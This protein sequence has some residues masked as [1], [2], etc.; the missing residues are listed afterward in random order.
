[1]IFPIVLRAWVRANKRGFQQRSLVPNNGIRQL[2][3]IRK[4]ANQI[5]SASLKVGKSNSEPLV[6]LGWLAETTALSILYMDVSER[7]SMK[8]FDLK[9]KRSTSTRI[10]TA[11]LS[12]N[13]AILKRLIDYKG[14]EFFFSEG[15]LV[16]VY[17]KG[18]NAGFLPFR[19]ADDGSIFPA[20]DNT[21]LTC[22]SSVTVADKCLFFRDQSKEIICVDLKMLTRL[23]R[24]RIIGANSNWADACSKVDRE[25]SFVTPGMPLDVNLQS[26]FAFKAVLASL[27][28]KKYLILVLNQISK[29]TSPALEYLIVDSF[30]CKPRMPSLKNGITHVPAVNLL[31]FDRA[32]G[33]VVM[34]VNHFKE[35][36]TTLLD[37]ILLNSDRAVFVINNINLDVPALSGSAI[38]RIGKLHVDLLLGLHGSGFVQHL[39]ISI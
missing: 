17:S 35:I 21:E 13:N 34:S 30:T 33:T 15:R 36:A 31:A 24:T 27:R 38:A 19:F 16:R 4:S 2:E 22:S 18:E 28:V 26:P 3:A 6:L 39:V 23:M 10:I 7:T 12:H 20:C 1:M 9:I 37:I 11:S 29:E 8:S 5:K 32:I 25:N 14:I